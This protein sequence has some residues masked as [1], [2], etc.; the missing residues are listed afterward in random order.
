MLGLE[1]SIHGYGG[2]DARLEAEHDEVWS[3]GDHPDDFGRNIEKGGRMNPTA[4]FMK[5]IS[6]RWLPCE[7]R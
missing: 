7:R 6:R 3:R 1:P 4:L 5:P 2:M